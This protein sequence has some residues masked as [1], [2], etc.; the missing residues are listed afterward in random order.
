ML[1]LPPPDPNE[2]SRRYSGNNLVWF[3]IMFLG[4][5]ALNRCDWDPSPEML[6]LGRSEMVHQAGRRRGGCFTGN[7]KKFLDAGVDVNVRDRDGRTALHSA[8]VEGCTDTVRLLLERGAHTDI[9]DGCTAL[10]LAERLGHTEIAQM[11]RAAGAS[12]SCAARGA[13]A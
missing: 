5:L 4:M 12:N 8:V 13:G 2:H 7:V 9:A 11:L 1:Q 6:R 3:A 10:M